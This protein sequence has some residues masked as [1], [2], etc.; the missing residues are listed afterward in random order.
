MK[1]KHGF[2]LVE[3]LITLG[4]IGVVAAMT[5]PGLMTAYKKHVIASSLKK[6]ISAINQAIKQSEAENGEMETWDK[7]TTHDIFIDK[8]IRPYMKIS[9]TCPNITD[10]YYKEQIAWR[11]LNNT[12]G[13]YC[14]PNINNRIPFITSDGILYTFAFD[15]D[16]NDRPNENLIIMD[17]NNSKGPNQFGQ[18][19]FFLLRKEE[20]DSIIPYGANKTK[21]EIQQNCSTEGSGMYCGAWIYQNGWN[22]PTGYPIK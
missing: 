5:I 1:K 7:S 9:M 22:L 20:E 4:I 12:I 17:I 14:N 13:S 19:V 3:V 6:G 8:Y 21:E 15:R 16:D 18:D 10:C 2:T 11:H